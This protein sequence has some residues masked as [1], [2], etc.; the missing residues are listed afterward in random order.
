MLSHCVL[1]ERRSSTFSVLET[2]NR[3]CRLG[4]NVTQV[5]IAVPEG[6]S[7]EEVVRID[8]GLTTALRSRFQRMFRICENGLTLQ[9]VIKEVFRK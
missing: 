4:K 3:V 9:L 5:K 6:T 7:G 2:F 8:L 1:Y